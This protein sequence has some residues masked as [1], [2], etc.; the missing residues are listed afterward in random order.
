M[1]RNPQPRRVLGEH[2]TRDGKPKKRFVSE[3]K[4]QEW[5]RSRCVSATV[6]PCTFCGGFHSASPKS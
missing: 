5:V 2:F 3:A 1:V 6:Y 4:A